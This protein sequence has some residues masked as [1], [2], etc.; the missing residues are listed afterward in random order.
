MSAG[1][2]KSQQSCKSAYSKFTAFLLLFFVLCQTPL[3]LSDDIT[4]DSSTASATRKATAIFAGGCFWCMEKPFDEQDGVLE[5]TSGYI[6]G[7]IKNPTYKAVSSG[8]TGHIEAVR[9]TYDPASVDYLTLLRIFW[10]NIDPFDATGQF[11]DKGTQYTSAIFVADDADRLTAE[12]TRQAVTD[13]FPGQTIATAIRPASDFYPA[14]NYHQ[15]YYQKNP[16]RYN[17]Y[18]YS[19]GRDQRL[20]EVWGDRKLPF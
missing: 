6:G 2:Y 13:M 9:V 1:S 11:C 12:K 3:A 16:I 20:T 15:N 10:R 5:T 14:E 18:R 8:T 19:C 7:K 4:A 17:Y